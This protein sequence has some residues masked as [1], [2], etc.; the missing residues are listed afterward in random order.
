LLISESADGNL[1]EK[2][3]SFFLGNTIHTN[4][5]NVWFCMRITIGLIVQTE[6]TNTKRKTLLQVFNL[7]SKNLNQI[8]F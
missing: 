7:H 5:N 3:Y 8:I 2:V 4:G 6:V 1:P